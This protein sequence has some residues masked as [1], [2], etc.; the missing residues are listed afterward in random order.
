MTIRVLVVDDSGFIR[1]RL[2]EILNADTGMEVVGSAAD[3]L[4]AIRQ[5][6]ALSPDVITMDVA[7]PV[8]NGI[9]AVRHIM[10][11]RPT[12]ILMFS[13]S[14]QAGAKATLDALEA[15]A[16]DF[17][18]KQLHEI[19]GD[20]ETAKQLLRRRV[21]DL[22]RQTARLQHPPALP[23]RP[24]HPTRAGAPTREIRLLAM[25]ASTGG[26][27]ALQHLL[28]RLPA[29]IPVPI[30]LVQ[31]MPGNFTGSFAERLDQIC[32]IAVREARNGDELRPGVALLAPGGCQ[33]ELMNQGPRQSVAVRP[34]L[35]GEYYHPSADVTFASIARNQP[36]RTLALVLTGMGSDGRQGAIRMKEKGAVI[37]AQSEASCVV[38]GMSKAIVDGNLADGIFDLD[39]MAEE[40]VKFPAWTR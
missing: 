29:D 19:S 12:P 10:R 39:E 4:E 17:L 36:G 3:G 16:M 34:P 28:A 21:R 18:P 25:A 9:D 31:H 23:A 27:V 5:T 13:V 14:T 24:P 30:L 20:R 26:P 11:E 33:M 38:Y 2:T 37:W 35:D 40:L 32:A 1:R 8:M 6:R 15:G 22:A 7:M